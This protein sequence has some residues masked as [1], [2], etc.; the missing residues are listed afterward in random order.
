MGPLQ[1]VFSIRV[2]DNQ[3]RESLFSFDF[4]VFTVNQSLNCHPRYTRTTAKGFVQALVPVS[5]PG[6]SDHRSVLASDAD[7]PPGQEYSH[8]LANACRP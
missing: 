4:N 3:I 1:L 5:A 8:A 6:D 2:S 7:S